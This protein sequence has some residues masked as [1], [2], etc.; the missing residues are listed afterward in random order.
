MRRTLRSFLLLA[1]LLATW[2]PTA[3][4]VLANTSREVSAAGTP[5]PGTH[6]VPE[7]A[8]PAGA[9]DVSA[10]VNHMSVADKIGQLFVVTF[11]GHNVTDTSD[12]ATL[13]RD[14]RVGG[15]NISV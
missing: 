2:L 9:D 5:T 4:P 8:T 12:I 6:S 3:A 7:T 15:I 1:C 10:I 13:V 14:Y 11:Q